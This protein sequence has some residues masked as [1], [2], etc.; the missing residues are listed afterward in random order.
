M[1]QAATVV[2]L[3]EQML[4][5][6][7]LV[8]R[9]GEVAVRCDKVVYRHQHRAIFDQNL[10]DRTGHEQMSVKVFTRDGNLDTVVE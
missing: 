8:F 9:S 1:Q 7:V 4:L 5:M 6:R 3:W 2:R 10:P